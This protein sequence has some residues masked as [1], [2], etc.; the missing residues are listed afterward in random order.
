MYGEP[1]ETDRDSNYPGKE[2]KE[3]EAFSSS[4]FFLLMCL[5]AKVSTAAAK[6]EKKGKRGENQCCRVPVCSLSYDAAVLIVCVFG[7][8][9]TSLFLFNKIGKA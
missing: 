3:E 1:R 9:E 6:K 4:F 2:R 5:P 8:W 7:C